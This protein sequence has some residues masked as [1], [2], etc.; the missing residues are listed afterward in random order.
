MKDLK[1]VF[2]GNMG[3]GKTTA[4][5]RLSEIS[6]V[7]TDVVNND[8]SHAKEMTTVGIDFGYVMLSEN[9]KLSLYGTP[10]QKRFSFMWDVV[11]KGALGVIVLLDASRE[12]AIDDVKMYINAYVSFGIKNI[13][14]GV[15]HLDIQ[16]SLTL[17][18]LQMASSHCEIDNFPIYPCDARNQQDILFLLEI[19]VAM[20]ES[21]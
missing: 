21:K 2:T 8:S 15:T 4:I 1:I 11:A 6:I 19:L 5:S 9:T 7:S 17:Y 13:I 10:G 16:D 20:I 12:E 3:A 14:I 18:D